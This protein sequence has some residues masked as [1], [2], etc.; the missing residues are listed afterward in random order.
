M[1][2]EAKAAAKMNNVR[3]AKII[4]SLENGPVFNAEYLL[5]VIMAT[6]A[7]HLETVEKSKFGKYTGPCYIYTDNCDAVISPIV[8]E[9]STKNECNYIK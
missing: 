5:N 7:D 4:Y 8:K 9:P 2:A 1:I 3:G 6:G